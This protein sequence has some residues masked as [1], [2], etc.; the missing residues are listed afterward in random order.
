MPSRILKMAAAFA[1][2]HGLHGTAMANDWQNATAL[3][4]AVPGSKNIH[5]ALDLS[6]CVEHDSGKPGPDVRGSLHP[7]ELMVQ[8]DHTIA[9]AMTHF[10]VRPDETPVDEFAGEEHVSPSARSRETFD[11]LPYTRTVWNR[12]RR[13]PTPAKVK[14]TI[15]N[16]GGRNDPQQDDQQR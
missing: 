8:K 10:T 1:G 14:Q 9:F 2:L 15:A 12:T 13:W 3:E 4:H 6:G 5:V 7:D 16:A 11:P